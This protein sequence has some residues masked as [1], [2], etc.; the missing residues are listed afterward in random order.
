VLCITGNGLKT[1]DALVNRFETEEPIAPK[2]SAFEN[3]LQNALEVA[4]PVEV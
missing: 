4:A 3:Y 2:I 1:T